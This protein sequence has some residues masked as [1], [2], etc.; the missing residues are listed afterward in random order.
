MAVPE[1]RVR[2]VDAAAPAPAKAAP[3]VAPVQIR[4]ILCPV[5]FTEFSAAALQQAAILARACGAEVAV[6]AV[7]PTE[8]DAA[9]RDAAAREVERFL[10]TAHAVGV[11]VRVCLKGGD[12]ANAVVAVAAE[13]AADVIVLADHQRGDTEP[14]T[15]S[16][17]AREV[18]TRVSCPVVTVSQPL[19]ARAP[20]ELP[21][22]RILCALTLAERDN[23][24]LDYAAHMARMTG[25]HLTLLHVLEDAGGLDAQPGATLDPAR[26]REL[27]EAR[28]R[29]RAAVSL[30]GAPC[31]AQVVNGGPPAR[32]ILR[33]AEEEAAALIVMGLH[34][35]DALQ[36]AFTGSTP[37]RVVR[38][39]RCPVMTVPTT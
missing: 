15:V 23:R 39:A 32:H 30:L 28:E 27:Q 17:L 18:L 33:T 10:R 31:D 25:R 8:P 19:D 37:E 5:D 20:T 6:L 16:A 1:K 11:P 29:L 3:R 2:P 34:A 35:R 24:T 21:G 9:G 13:M 12:P 7:S 26:E 36:P 4:R 38:E 14:G 22:A